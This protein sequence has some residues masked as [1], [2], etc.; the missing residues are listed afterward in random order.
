M[1]LDAA[2]RLFRGVFV[3]GE[4][5][6]AGIARWFRGLSETG[7]KPGNAGINYRGWKSL[8]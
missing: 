6:F 2:A 7:G 5:G 8:L 1:A 3:G 4:N